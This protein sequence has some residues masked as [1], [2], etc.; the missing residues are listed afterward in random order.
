[1]NR[2]AQ[3][4]R[5]IRTFRHLERQQVLSRAREPLVDLADASGPRSAA[6]V[7]AP[8]WPSTFRSTDSLLRAGG[9]GAEG[10]DITLL[11]ENRT[12]GPPAEWDW[13]APAPRGYGVSTSTTG[14]GRTRR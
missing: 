7:T 10:E 8:G 14:I 5:L 12:M 1:M 6:P 13:T 2:R 9:L 11:G 4:G 3:A